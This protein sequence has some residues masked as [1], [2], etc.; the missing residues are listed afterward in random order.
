MLVGIAEDIFATY[1]MKSERDIHL[2]VFASLP[3]VEATDA[4]PT[5]PQFSS[6]D[7]LF[8]DALF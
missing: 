2:A 8:D 3:A 6:D 1:T 4:G 7:A 5:E